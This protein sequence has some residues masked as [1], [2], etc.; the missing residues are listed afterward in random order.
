MKKLLTASFLGL[1][2][3]TGCNAGSVSMAPLEQMT[4]QS[5]IICDGN[6]PPPQNPCQ[7]PH[8]PSFGTEALAPV[9][10]PC[11]PKPRPCSFCN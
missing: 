9:T 4:A 11:Q 5:G 7:Q 10:T 6:C 2:V 8:H 1:M 3:L